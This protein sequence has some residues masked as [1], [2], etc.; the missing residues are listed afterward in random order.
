MS[1][2]TEHGIVPVAA[3]KVHQP[4]VD[5]HRQVE[6]NLDSSVECRTVSNALEKSSELTTTKGLN[7]SRLITV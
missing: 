7:C 6:F 2:S 3:G 4:V 5:R 1:V